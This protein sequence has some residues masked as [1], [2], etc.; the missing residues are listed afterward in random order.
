MRGNVRK[1]TLRALFAPLKPDAKGGHMLLG[2]LRLVSA[3]HVSF[4]L[5]FT[6]I[7]VDE[8]HLWLG[9]V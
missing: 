9:F 7:K 8:L 4:L 2:L 5:I 6:D 3:S 1:R